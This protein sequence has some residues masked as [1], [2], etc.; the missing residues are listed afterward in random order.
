MMRRLSVR[1]AGALLLALTAVYTSAATA[2]DV[3][4][5]RYALERW[6]AAPYEVVVLRRG[7]LSADEQRLVQGL[8]NAGAPGGHANLVVRS[9]DLARGG[10]GDAQRLWGQAGKH[11]L[12]CLVLCPPRGERARHVIW[13]GSLNAGSARLIADSPARRE[14]ARRILQGH[15]AIWVLLKSGDPTKD[16]AAETLLAKSLERLGQELELPAP[17]GAAPLDRRD[18]DRPVHP[19]LQIR[20]SVLSLS[21]GDRAESVFIKTLL[22]SEPD[23]EEYSSEPL[24]FPI[25]G[26]GRTLYGL[27]GKGISERNIRQACEIVVS[28]CSCAVKDENPGTDLLLAANWQGGLTGSVVSEAEAPPLVSLAGVSGSAAAAQK[29]VRAGRKRPSGTAAAPAKPKASAPKPTAADTPSA[30]SISPS[31]GGAAAKAATAA[32]EAAPAGAPTPAVVPPRS[33]APAPAAA[34][35]GLMRNMAI[36]LGLMVGVTAVLVLVISRRTPGERP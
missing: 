10:D 19:P 24:A 9:T 29:T 18:P 23:L 36:A 6:A 1:L 28:A 26:R 16:A 7:P 35:G 11:P 12:P 8:E 22:D 2:C 31:V 33:A 3:P 17:T 13:S 30:T 4:V 34:P 21:R 27:V 15:S 14:V 25:Y 32:V 5:F 20:F